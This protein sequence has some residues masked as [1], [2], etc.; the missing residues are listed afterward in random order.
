MDWYLLAFISALFSA[1]AAISQKKIL[2]DIEALR[3]STLLSIFLI[4]FGLLFI[5]ASDINDIQLIGIVIL[6][7]KTILGALSFWCVMLAI[8]NMEISGALPLLV[9]TP[10]FVAILSFFVLSEDLSYISIV[11]MLLLLIGTYILETKNSNSFLYP[12]KIFIKSRFHHYI[13]YALLLFTVSSVID[14][15][16]LKK[17]AIQPYAFVGFQQIFLAVNFLII[18]VIVKK[19]IKTLFTNLNFAH[20]KWIFLIAIFTVLYRYTQIE[21]V[22]LAPVALVLSIKRTSVFFATVIGGKIFLEHRLFRK[23]MATILM[24]IGAYLIILY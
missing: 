22:K 21:A 23:A 5:L 15:L 9:L 14:K 3:F 2:F 17:F 8:K 4:P 16:L 10:G 1:A 19:D 18:F 7:V 13:V 24:L 20:I 12:F 11:G 6:Y